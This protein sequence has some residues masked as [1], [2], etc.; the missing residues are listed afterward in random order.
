MHL[1]KGK[2]EI[3]SAFREF[4]AAAEN[5][6]GRKIQF[7]QTDNGKEFRNDAFDD[8]LRESGIRRRLT[9]T[10][11][12]QQNGVAERR[13]RT[14]LDMTRCLLIE[15]GLPASFWDKAEHGKLHP[16]PM[17]VAQPPG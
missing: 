4:K 12:P 5:R 11:T 3:L 9:V 17:P 13:N 2:N 14:L 8:F 10:H 16:K 15:S 7:L 1:L 6:H